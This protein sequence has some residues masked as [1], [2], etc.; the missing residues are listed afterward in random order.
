VVPFVI[1]QWVGLLMCIFMPEIIMW[2]PRAF[3]GASVG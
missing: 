1:L 2:A 3:F